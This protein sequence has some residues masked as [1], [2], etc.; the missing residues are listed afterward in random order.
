V[1]WTD[2]QLPG[3]PSICRSADFD[4]ADHAGRSMIEV[5][6]RAERMSLDYAVGVLLQSPSSSIPA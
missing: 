1:A 4:V 6:G 2:P 3:A 5:N